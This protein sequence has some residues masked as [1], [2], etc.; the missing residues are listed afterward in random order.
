[1][2]L[3][4]QYFV[5]EIHPGEGL[6]AVVIVMVTAQIH[7]GVGLALDFIFFHKCVRVRASRINP[8]L[9]FC[10]VSLRVL[11]YLVLVF[12]N[13]LFTKRRVGRDFYRPELK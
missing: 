8:P 9:K 10:E 13:Y 5:S 7:K 1:M 12:A 6:T 3:I 2:F 11:H 4:C